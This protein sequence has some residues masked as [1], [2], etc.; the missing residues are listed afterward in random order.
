MNS[1]VIN[2]R[3]DDFTNTGVM[4]FDDLLIALHPNMPFEVS[5]SLEEIDEI[6]FHAIGIKFNGID[7]D[8]E[9]K[10]LRE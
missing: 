4:T 7:I 2:L 8:T 1:P 6:E 3:R 10:P 5:E 9:K